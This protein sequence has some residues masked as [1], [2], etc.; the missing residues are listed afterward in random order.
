M[1]TTDAMTAESLQPQNHR[2][3]NDLLLILGLLLVIAL[4]ALSLTVI[5]QSGDTVTVRVDGV[6]QGEYRL[7]EDTEVEIR[8]PNGYNILVIENGYAYVREAS[9]PD[10][11]CVSHRPIS[12]SGESIIC[13]PNKVVIELHTQ[14]RTDQPDI[15]S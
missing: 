6:L 12:H 1:K 8:T 7:S 4:A 14:D 9:C 2:R 10:G 11:I 5:R 13:L 3:R 15:I